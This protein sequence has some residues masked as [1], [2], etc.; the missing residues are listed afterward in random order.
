MPLLFVATLVVFASEQRPALRGM[1]FKWGDYRIQ[2]STRA[3]SARRHRSR[4][5]SSPCRTNSSPFL[6]RRSATTIARRTLH[7]TTPYS[8]RARITKG[9]ACWIRRWACWSCCGRWRSVTN[10]RRRRRASGTA[11][12]S[13]TRSD[14]V[15]ARLRSNCCR[16]CRAAA[17][18][19]QTTS[20]RRPKNS[21]PRVCSTQSLGRRAQVSASHTSD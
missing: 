21:A 20:R 3:R 4:K 9:A 19:Q 17:A 11:A 16:M 5:P 7:R 13:T 10:T 14:R 12:P 8:Q 6:P 1:E 2:V 15:T 18:F